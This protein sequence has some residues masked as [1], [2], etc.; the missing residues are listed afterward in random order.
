MTGASSVSRL[1]SISP[2]KRGD[3]GHGVPI[4]D[5]DAILAHMDIFCA[6]IRQLLEVINTMAQY[7]K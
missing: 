5:E 3:M 6:R 2:S 4:T 7:N 1:T